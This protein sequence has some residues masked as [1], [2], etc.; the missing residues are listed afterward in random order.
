MVIR[1]ILHDNTFS[2]RKSLCITE[3]IVRKSYS[4]DGSM[5][6]CSPS[7]NSAPVSVY[8]GGGGCGLCSEIC[9][10]DLHST[11]IHFGQLRGGLSLSTIFLG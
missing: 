2:W 5:R 11:Y 10:C 3:R 6:R 1:F 4:G 8:S 9:S 7:T